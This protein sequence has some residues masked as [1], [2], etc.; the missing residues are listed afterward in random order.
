MALVECSIPLPSI[1]VSSLV[2]SI[3][4]GVHC[5]GLGQNTMRSCGKLGTTSFGSC[6]SEMSFDL[7]VCFGTWHATSDSTCAGAMHLEHGH[8]LDT[9]SSFPGVF[10]IS[11]KRKFSQGL[12]RMNNL[13]ALWDL[14]C[15]SVYDPLMV[16][17]NIFSDMFPTIFGLWIA[18]L[19]SFNAIWKRV[20]FCEC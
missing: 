6:N 3:E 18:C 13:F 7:P 15:T 19:P 17:I 11:P 8:H 10:L 9:G 12:K 5:C 2:W 4:G 14:C 1:F 16:C 20:H